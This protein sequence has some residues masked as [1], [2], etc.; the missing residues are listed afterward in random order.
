MTRAGNS[1]GAFGQAGVTTAA[2]EQRDRELSSVLSLAAC[3]GFCSRFVAEFGF[4]CN[5]FRMVT[6]F[7]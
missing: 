7:Q 4:H 5:L 3:A 2:R 6:H 1:A